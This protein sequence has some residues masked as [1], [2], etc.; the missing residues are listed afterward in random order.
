MVMLRTSATNGPPGGVEC[1]GFP[2]FRLN[3]TITVGSDGSHGKRQPVLGI[4]RKIQFVYQREHR[5]H[6]LVRPP[7]ECNIRK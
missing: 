4:L 1:G 6:L 2:V 7:S 3:T 5:V